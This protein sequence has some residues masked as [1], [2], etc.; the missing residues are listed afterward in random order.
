V[1]AL[2]TTQQVTGLRSPPYGRE[3]M[4]ALAA[5]K[6]PNVRLY[7]CRPD[8]WTPARA[9]RDAFGPG[10]TLVLPVDAD[11]AEFRWPPIRN[12]VANVAGLPGATLHA[13]ALALVR[14]GLVLG[15]L[16]DADHPKRNLRVV[17]KRRAP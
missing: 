10:A 14:D 2:A 8:P 1:N 4:A 9:H 7:A 5:G 12:L 3:V 6:H 16:L 17:A 11:P 13:L 15:Y